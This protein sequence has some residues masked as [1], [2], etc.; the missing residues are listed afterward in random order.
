MSDS[1]TSI[2]SAPHAASRPVD[3]RIAVIAER[4]PGERRV[5]LTP[6][7]VGRL[8]AAGRPVTVERGAGVPAGF[9]DDAYLAAGATVS[10]RADAI[11]PG[12]VVAVVNGSRWHDD[13]Q[14]DLTDAVGPEHLLVGL[15][16]PLWR[17]GPMAELARTGA[18]VH[19]LDLLPRITRAQS[20][21]VLSSMATVAGYEASLLAASRVGVLA[22]MM[23]TAAGTI[24]AARAVVLGAGVAGLQAIATLRRLGARVEGYDVRPAAMEQIQSLGARAIELDLD[25]GDAEGEGGYARE[26]GV[27]RTRRQQELLTPHLAAADIVVTTAAIPGAASPELIT[28]EMVEAMESGAVIVDLAAERGGN[29]A[30][31]EADRTIVHQGVIIVGPTDLPSRA[32]TTASQLFAT[33]LGTYLG[34]V[35][36]AEPGDEIVGATTVA[37]GGHIVSDRVAERLAELEP[38]GSSN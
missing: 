31:T 17:P 38:E 18:T 3:E 23:M 30:L 35:A 7:V 1:D 14:R 8:T 15:F 5:A 2:E 20:M 10:D 11:G 25:G 4:A 36:A 34:H 19:A 32:P 21:D 16:D 28:A 13:D 24:P 22:P 12:G 33:N 29:C 6:L 27:D 9:D 26:Q 37:S